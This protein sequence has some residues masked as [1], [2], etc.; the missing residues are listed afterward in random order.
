M[1]LTV[2]KAV[3]RIASSLVELSEPSERPRFC[4]RLRGGDP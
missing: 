2:T 1:H 3:F 4:P